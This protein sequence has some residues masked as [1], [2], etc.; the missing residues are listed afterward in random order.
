[1][2]RMMMTRNIALLLAAGIVVAGCDSGGGAAANGKAAGG[3]A[4][5]PVKTA[6]A[7]ATDWTRT[8]VATPEGGFRMGNP[9]ARV[10][11]VE[12]ASYTCGACK[13]FH[14]ESSAPL[15][16][17]YVKSG[18]VSM[19]YRPFML[20]IYDFAAVLLATCEGPAKAVVWTDE[21]YGS[22]DA[23]VKKFGELDEAA[24]APLRNLPPDQ[25]I[26]GLAEAGKLHEFARAR[27]MTKATFDKCLA[28]QP[29]LERKMKA[30]EVAQAKYK[31]QG[32]P[33]F[34]LNGEKIE[35]SGWAQIEPQIKAKL[36]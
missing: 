20:N 17:N 30:Q 15:K 25:Q 1:M 8:V 10:K 6:G 11:L 36:G 29:A 16:A 2:A 26:R 5:V 18:Q 32:T 23:W 14:T 22:H 35:G 7:T 31:I 12:Y 21:L 4:A 3:T 34:L 27:G 13:N 9:D 28:D 33:T 19:E 24:I